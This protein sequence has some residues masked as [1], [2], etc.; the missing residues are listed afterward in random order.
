MIGISKHIGTGFG[1]G[2]LFDV[3]TQ[4]Q[5][6]G[7]GNQGEVYFVENNAGSDGNDGSS[8]DKAFKTLAK[9]I[10]VS[11]AAIAANSKGWA[12]RNTIFIKGDACEVDL[13]TGATKCDIIGVGSCDAEPRARIIGEHAFTGSSTQMGMRFFNL[14]FVND[15]TSALF[16]VTTPYG[17]EWHNCWFTEG[18]DCT[19]AIV[20]DGATG[21]R[22]VIEGC[23][24]RPRN[25]GTKFATAAIDISTVLT[26]GLEIRNNII[27]GTIGI[28]IDT[29][30]GSIHQAYIDNNV[31]IATGMVIDDES[32]DCI[33]TNNRMMSAGDNST[34]TT[35]IQIGTALAA[36]NILTGTDSTQNYPVISD[37]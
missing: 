26:Y 35:V 36:G 30:A 21:T 34:E 7:F 25:T 10:T 3:L 8:W 1:K 9:A 29:A 31:I 2:E 19:H 4:L 20:T 23:V 22:V 6:L 14:E 12:S 11:N 28:D 17:I 37:A 24:F 27:D 16:T 32:E 33:V 15:D 13:T 18:A 5:N